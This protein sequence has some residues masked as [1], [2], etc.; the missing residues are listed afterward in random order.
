MIENAA[1]SAELDKLLHKLLTTFD[2]ETG[3]LSESSDDEDGD[4]D[5][6]SEA[7]LMTQKQWLL[8]TMLTLRA[9]M[10]LDAG[11]PAIA[12]KYL[13]WC[14]IQCRQY[15]R[16]LRSVSCHF[17]SVPL[18][19]ISIQVDC[20]L[21]KCYE[22][23]AHAFSRLGLRRKAEDHAMLAVIKSKVLTASGFNQISMPDLIES[24]EIYDEQESFVRPIRSLMRVK[25]LSTSTDNMESQDIVAENIGHVAIPQTENRI[26]SINRL[27]CESENM[28][29]CE[30]GLP[31]L[32][33]IRQNILTHFSRSLESQTMI[34][35]GML[36]KRL[37][38]TL[39]APINN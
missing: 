5:K 35:F 14:R 16:Y 26:A 27:L 32:W 19:D 6:C 3:A 31:V 38:S 12:V 9:N 22:E 7:D 10:Y 20:L 30:Y 29:A 37:N 4:P 33:K 8:T 36:A 2:G 11:Y 17:N 1:P 25:A 13:E 28:L 24:V 21:T 18:D 39:T 15:A 23:M 34:P